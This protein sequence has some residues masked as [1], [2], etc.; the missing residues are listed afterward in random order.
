MWPVARTA[1]TKAR[2]ALVAGL[3]AIVLLCFSRSAAADDLDA[4]RARGTLNW[5]ADQEGG[6][7]YVYPRDDNVL[8]APWGPLTSGIGETYDLILASAVP[9]FGAQLRADSPA[10]VI[11][12][13]WS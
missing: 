5:G 1:L 8:G 13:P 7:P 11:S 12:W 2:L 6:G 9:H 10:A 3:V 4:V